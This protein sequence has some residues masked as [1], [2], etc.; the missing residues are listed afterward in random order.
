M[1]SAL[2]QYDYY[3]KKIQDRIRL[4]VAIATVAMVIG[5]IVAFTLPPKYEA[6]TTV[7]LEQNV[8]TDLVKG[9]AVSPSVEAKLKMLSVALLSRTMILKVLGELDRDLLLQNERKLEEYLAFLIKRISISYKEKQGVFIITLRDDDP[10]FARDFVNTLTRKYIDESTSSKREESYEA[11]K[12]LAE[13]IDSFKRRID[14]ADDAIN[15]YKS[16]KGLLLATDDVYLRGEIASAEK[17]LEELSIKRSELEAKKRI[18]LE[19]GSEPGK[20]SEAEGRLSEL[21]AR[22]TF[23]HPKVVA[24]QAEVSRLRGGRGDQA[25]SRNA[26]KIKDSVQMLQVELDA[27]KE[28]EVRQLRIIED[29]K[30]LLREIPNV[31]ST[32]AELVKKKDN[33]SVVY[34]QLVARYGQSEVSKQMELQDKSITFRILDPAVIPLKPV[35]PNRLLIILIGVVGGIGLGGGVVILLDVL[36]GGIKSPAELKELDVPVLAIVSHIVDVPAEA[37]VRRK[38]RVV[39]GFGV[40]CMLVVFGFAAF[41]VFHLSEVATTSGKI[42][43]RKINNV[44]SR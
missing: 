41:D 14:A 3:L 34:Q 18:Y 42:I 28:M 24:A 43:S 20:L 36:K 38:D 37:E 17:K 35:S 44:I 25:H 33:E 10:V 13:Q 1:S 12:F 9:I 22:Y 5:V 11:N 8:I 6:R 29:S 21:L 19:R 26:A 30:N 32:L 40:C 15:R 39:V 7:F 4:F 31:K 23:E 27:Y 16:E 2:H